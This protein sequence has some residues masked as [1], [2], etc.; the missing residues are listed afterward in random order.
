LDAQR[1]AQAI[2]TYRMLQGR[3]PYQADG[4]A[5]KPDGVYENAGVV[6][7]LQGLPDR[8][9]FFKV[10]PPHLNA[11]GSFVDSWRQPFRIVMWKER[12]TDALNRH[13]QVYSCGQNM[14]WDEGHKGPYKDKNGKTVTGDDITADY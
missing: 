1:M 10:H 9:Q 13:F 12:S 8:E 11:K 14:R 4:E 5:D 7:Q 6:R 2:E 3:L